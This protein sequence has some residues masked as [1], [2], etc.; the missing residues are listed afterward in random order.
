MTKE[1][2]SYFVELSLRKPDG[3][4]NR[5]FRVVLDAYSLQ[6]AIELATM[7]AVGSETWNVTCTEAKPAVEQC[8]QC[9]GTGEVRIPGCY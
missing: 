3:S 1:P 7:R 4:E 5:I 6:E 8:R 9:G 2:K